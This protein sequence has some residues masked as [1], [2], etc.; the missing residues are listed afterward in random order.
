M[1][2]VAQVRSHGSYPINVDDF[3]IG[4]EFEVLEGSKKTSSGKIFYSL[5][6]DPRGS[7]YYRIKE[8]GSDALGRG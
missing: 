8:I 2:L 7:E 4:K 5:K 3:P 6:D 1:K